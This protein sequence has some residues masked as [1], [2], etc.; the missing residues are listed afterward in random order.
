MSK[1]FSVYFDLGKKYQSENNLIQAKENFVNAAKSLLHIAK[2]ENNKALKVDYINKAEGLIKYANKLIGVEEE[3]K[4]ET[5]KSNK[6]MFDD[7]IGL[8][9]V[10]EVLNS[11]L[12]LP[13]EHKEVFD[14]FNKKTNGGLLLYGPPGTGKT[15]VVKAL[16]NEIG[17]E[18]Y[19]IRCSDI[20][21]KYVGEAEQKIKNL[22]TDARTHEK[23]VIFF[24]EFDSIAVK[25]GDAASH[26]DRIVSE[27]LSQIDGF[28]TDNKNII[29]IAATNLP[30][31]ID[32]AILRPPRFT[33]SIYID[34][35]N[36][37]MRTFLFKKKLEGVSLDKD[38]DFSIIS[39][40]TKGFSGA[41]IEEVCEKSKMAPIYRSIK[42]NSI[43]N[44]KEQDI[45]DV[46][47]DSYPSVTKEY[48]LKYKEYNN[49]KTTKKKSVENE[50][51]KRDEI[52][53][54]NTT[55]NYNVSSYSYNYPSLELLNNNKDSN[56]KKPTNKSK[57]IISFLNDIK[58][59]FTDEINVIHGPVF[60]RYEIIV[61]NSSH[62]GDIVK[63][64]KD[65]SMR[66]A[67]K[68]IR[69]LAPIPGKNA[70]G[71]EIP[72]DERQMV[73]FKDILDK[74]DQD[75]PEIKFTLGVDLLNNP[76]KSNISKAP[77]ILVAGSTGSGKSVCIN[78]LILNLVYNYSP[79]DLRLILVDP[80]YV[81]LN[82]YANLPHLL[83]D[84]ILHTDADAIKALNFLVKEME[85]RYQLLKK[86]NVKSI[87]DFNKLGTA[88]LP[89][90]VL[91]IDEMADLMSSSKKEIEDRVQR[92]AQLARAAG[93]HIIMAT[94][95]PSA[96]ILT[97]KIK[98]N[99]PERISFKLTTS[100]DSRTIIN[101][102]G[103]ENLLGNGDLLFKSTT[104]SIVRLQGPYVSD[105]EINKVINYVVSNNQA[106]NKV[107]L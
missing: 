84:S 75:S 92:I 33:D 73:S 49:K 94:Q 23:A 24:D 15:M 21:T 85:D 17:A 51:D 46:L 34:L 13:L 29:I 6:I 11:K 89:K 100:H 99:I 76:Y 104:D 54:D 10:K 58:F 79:S 105:E 74:D 47:E 35:P 7:V 1:E 88:H 87:D 53:S 62:I 61:G 26:M 4:V 103:A 44:L 69:L 5:K 78:S 90:L 8:E 52:Y 25:R 67:A 30:W 77:H 16:A 64:E 91:I 50:D 93:I 68:S 80:K 101:E 95:R 98:V 2:N 12:V 14:A 59:D 70:I 60:T 42:S 83:T 39:E 32:Q 36:K 72:N 27:L 45:L 43:E 65:L 97:S 40:N 22:F 48:L 31:N 9:S 3:P 37:R 41:D 18:F 63:Y 81:E 19:S 82:T 71:I 56:D 66:L 57:D 96:D 106:T 38:I 20:L 102:K 55:S 107:K 86:N 28:D